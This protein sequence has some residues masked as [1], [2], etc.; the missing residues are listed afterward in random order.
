MDDAE[1]CF[2]QMLLREGA[3]NQ[4]APGLTMYVRERDGQ[5]LRGILV[6][7]ARDST[8]VITLLA[9]RWRFWRAAPPVPTSG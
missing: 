8:A 9:E 6:H 3:F 5:E 1:R 4:I 7:D 2:T